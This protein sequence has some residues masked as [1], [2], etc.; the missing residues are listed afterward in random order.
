MPRREHD[1]LGEVLVPDG[2]RYG[3]QTQRA[4]ENFPISGRQVPMA[5]VHAIGRVKAAAAVANAASAAVPGIDE[6]IA[7]AIQT[8]ANEVASGIW[9]AEFPIDVFQT[10]SGTSTN[11]NANEVIASRASELCDQPIHPNDHVNA[12]QSSNDVV[13]T[14]IRLSVALRLR[15]ELDPALDGLVASLRSI[16]ANHATVVKAGRTHMMDAAPL[17]VGD[18]VGAWASQLEFARQQLRGALDALMELPIGG[19]AVGTGLNVPAGWIDTVIEEL[20]AATALP[21]RVSSDRFAAMAGGDVYLAVSAALRG[22][23][24]AL[25]KVCNDLRL[26][27]S[28][29]MC[30]LAEFRLPTLQPGSSIMPGKVNPV[31]PE[32]LLQVAA[33]VAGNDT[34]VMIGA[35]SGTLQLNTYQPIIAD[36]LHESIGVL[37]NGMRLLDERCVRGIEVDVARCAEYAAR[38]PALVTGLVS[39][40]GYERAAHAVQRSERDGEHLRDVLLA[41]GLE[42]GWL[43]R[44]LDPQRL[45]RGGVPDPE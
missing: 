3:A 37:A 41:D 38:S 10:G 22:L 32:A 40:L 2:V 30:G 1:S 18:E 44:V 36:A 14:A 11:M 19:S 42:P 24:I 13:P 12:S 39:V 29:P 7:A 35:A 16:A 31:I 5:L 43:D 27:S 17:F 28:G 45:A 9:D 8:A 33:R 4:V 25:T 6:S 20:R 21:L 26:L 15:D 34:T 23:A